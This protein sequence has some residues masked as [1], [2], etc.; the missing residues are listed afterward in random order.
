MAAYDYKCPLCDLIIP[1]Q[2]SVDEQPVVNCQLCDEQM[3]KVFSAPTITFK[4]KGWG[5]Q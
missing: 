5:S 2:H 4:G 1:V 3:R